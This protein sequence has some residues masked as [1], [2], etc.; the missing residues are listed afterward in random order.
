[1]RD[2]KYGGAIL[3]DAFVYL[4]RVSLDLVG[5]TRSV[6]LGWRATRNPARSNEYIE[7]QAALRAR[8]ADR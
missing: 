5:R 2:V 4:W 8:R 6:L 1:V 3:A 7:K